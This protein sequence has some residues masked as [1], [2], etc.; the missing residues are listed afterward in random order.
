MRYDRYSLISIMAHS[1]EKEIL[2]TFL[3]KYLN[4]NIES[5]SFL[6]IQINGDSKNS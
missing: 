3:E 6:Q 1:K 4:T 5:E 2:V